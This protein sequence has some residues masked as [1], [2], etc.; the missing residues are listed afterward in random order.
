[1]TKAGRVLTMIAVA[2]LGFGGYAAVAQE[3]LLYSFPNGSAGPDASGPG[4]S[5]IGDSSGNLYGTTQLGG[6][7]GEGTVF[8]LSPAV[9]GG[10]TEKVLYSFGQCPQ[11]PCSGASEPEGSL[12]FDAQGNLYGTTESGGPGG[13]FGGRGT[14]FEL[15]PGT[16]GVWTETTLYEFGGVTGDGANPAAALIFDA[17]ENLYGT[18][19]AG[20]ANGKGAVFEL[21]P[22]T[23][24]VWT[25]K[26]LYS[27]AGPAANPP[28][29]QDPT[30][31]LIFDAQG[32]LYG[33]TFTG[34][35][36]DTTGE[37]GTVFEMS[38][39][40]GGV[41]TEKVLYN[42][43][44]A[45]SPDGNQPTASLIFDSQGNLYGTTREG[46][47][48][49]DGTVFE[50]SPAAGGTW[51]ESL[52]H[53]F[54]GAPSDGAVPYCS[55]FFD[56]QGN[57][58]GTTKYGGPNN[59][60]LS[61]VGNYLGSGMVF[62]LTP[63]GGGAWT[64]S[65]LYNFNATGSDGTVP[66]ASLIPDTA[67][68][69]Y[70]TTIDGG[71]TGNA[72][73]IGD[74]SVFEI[75]ATGLPTFSPAAGNYGGTQNVTI[76]SATP[77]AAI[78]YTTNG[79]TPTTSSTKYTGPIA[80][81]EAET[82]EA[83][84]TIAG[85]PNSAVASAA[86][87]FQLTAAATPVI[88]PTAGTFTATQSVT[89]TDS[90][91]G[92]VIYYTT[93]GTTPTAS[94]TKYTGAISVSATETIE[95]VAVASNFSNS[96]VAS[97]TY[98]INLPAAAAPTFSPAVGTFTSA[99]SVTL[100]DSTAG[101]VIYYTTNGTTPTASSTQYSG[102]ISVSSTETIE[103]IAIAPGFANSI[104]ST[105]TYTINLT[106]ATP[107]ISPAA[108]TF[109][110]TQSVT[111]TDSTDGAFIYYTTNGTTPTAA[112]TQYSG[113]I[114]VSAT[115]TIEAI[116]IA[117]GYTNSAVASATY[118]INL[119]A[120]A[121]PVFSPAAGTFTS[122]Q[123]VTIADSTA[124]ATI[125]YTTNGTTPTAAS[126]QY[127]GAISVSATETIEAIAVA[128]GF[129]NSAVATADYVIVVTPPG[130]TLAA[131]PPSL[132]IKSG[133]TGTTVIT[134]TPTGGFTG[135]VSFTC[136]TLPSDV[137]CSF[138]PGTLTVPSTGALTTTL[139]VGTGGTA[140]ASLSGGTNGT[141]L[142][143]VF[144][145]MILL[146]LGF[147]RRMLRA[148]KAGNPWLMGLLLLATTSVAA[149]GMA[150]LTGCGGPS[151]KSTPAGTYSI[152]IEVTS[153]GTA[154]PLNLSITVQ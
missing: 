92:A 90:T 49:L 93:N 139:T 112:S 153:G 103:A 82:I 131:N 83:F 148:R 44:G 105:A 28:D 43:G 114:S 142:P 30:G 26:V 54:T 128:S 45:N 134:L 25:E 60:T 55:L 46:G 68:N 10:W 79:T 136:G 53:N 72:N 119:A 129:S 76:T 22:G 40:A 108:G 109:T 19:Q 144:V 132:T 42:F 94:S 127:S 47:S 106:A 31:N 138:A 141:F 12:V 69:L 89:I 125:Y 7:K 32:N 24:G 124:G 21:S 97:A 96:A 151:K 66:G 37:G 150:G 67:G 5:L 104:V 62:E 122:T 81:S 99:Q 130:Y 115:E 78:Y 86:Y 102:A 74:G 87:T 20:G 107:V 39:G 154:V 116:A 59:F 120:A 27:F 58:Y 110:S 111:I 101:A 88:S 17:T 73:A 14:V 34:G 1:M 118:T 117:T 35:K 149:A 84:A 3:T 71:A 63:G 140:M 145:A 152:P 8:E 52:L 70:S 75:G 143:E 133:A 100:S 11:A 146:P 15:S 64:E 80:V 77:D 2:L 137:T 95:A 16:G 29:G 36:N 57:L 65:I 18:T 38:P 61:P 56:A 6:A 147:T 9:G 4:A 48:S 123:S 50:L 113:A 33:T 13:E 91:A 41:W 126:T 98:T 85:S 121:T 135:T 23:G 51:T